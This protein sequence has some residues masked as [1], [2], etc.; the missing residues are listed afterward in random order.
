MDES[1]KGPALDDGEIIDGLRR[2]DSRITRDYFYGYCRVAYSIYNRRYRLSGKPG[3]D[4]YDVAHEYYIALS[5]HEFRQLEDR[6]PGTSLKTWMVNGFRFVLLDRLKAYKREF[7]M[8]DIVARANADSDVIDFVA[9]ADDDFASEFHRSLSE[10]CNVVEAGNPRQ[11]H[12]MRML[13]IDG[14]KGKEVAKEMGI[15]AAAVS[16][17]FHKIMDTIVVPYF[18]RDSEVVSTYYDNVLSVHD[19]LESKSLAPR[20]CKKRIFNL[21]SIRALIDK[22]TQMESRREAEAE[23]ERVNYWLSPDVQP[24]P[25]RHE[26]R[27]TPDHISSLAP[28]E[29]FV[30]GSNLAGL[31]GGGASLTAHSH[32]GAE[33]GNGDGPRGNSYAIPTMLGGVDAI[34]PY[35]DKF[36]SY[37]RK[38]SDKTF[39]VIQIGCGVAGFYPDDIAPLFAKAVDV[40]N[41]HL[42]LSFWNYLDNMV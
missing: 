35:V 24:T 22:F 31:H 3:L 23:E 39:L 6:K 26:G 12:I 42:P 10:L 5:T 9:V 21:K 33:L 15:S 25:P 13:C 36:V 30:F 40:E 27:I 38:H 1:K 32:F 17:Q 20:E 2:H 11:G 4:F 8:E 41:I 7:P 28:G 18:R 37:A 16:Q 14:Y 34:R 19:V 29:V